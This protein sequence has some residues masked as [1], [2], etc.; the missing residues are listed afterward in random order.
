MAAYGLFAAG[1]LVLVA[2]VVGLARA[3]QS[4]LQPTA[5]GAR[6][7]GT[8]RVIGTAELYLNVLLSQAI[9]VGLLVGIV[10]ASRVPR[11]ALGIPLEGLIDW[12]V[13]GIGVALGVALYLA[14]E[15]GVLVLDHFGIGYSEDLRGALAPSTLAGWV[16]LLVVVLPVI[17]GAEE[18][19][20][21][22]ALIGGFDAGFGIAP[23]V[24][25]LG[26][27]ALFAL[28]HGMQGPGGV[29]V[30]GALGVVLGAAFVVTGSL[31]LVIVAHYVVNALEFVIH[32]GLEVDPV[33]GRRS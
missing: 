11:T 24:L 22:A 4:Q 15:G 21:R 16:V 3:S 33:G 30:T 9:V 20:F 17:A 1:T 13:L 7:A 6:L 23:W 14:N 25:V 32:E 19:L 12:R 27:S 26:S 29:L 2:F 8:D 5:D 31:L 18:L 28:G 10:W